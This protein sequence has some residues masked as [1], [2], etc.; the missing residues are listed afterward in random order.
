M[1]VCVSAARP[2][3]PDNRDQMSGEHSNVILPLFVTLLQ[4]ELVQER[5]CQEVQNHQECSVQKS[6]SV[7]GLTSF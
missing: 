4:D 5:L 7:R 3:C 1:C 6:I 2:G